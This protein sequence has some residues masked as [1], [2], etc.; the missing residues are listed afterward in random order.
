MPQKLDDWQDP[1][2]VHRNRQDGHTALGVFPDVA[3]ALAG[4]SPYSV[5]LDGTWKFALY[6]NPSAVPTAFSEPGY[7]DSAWA[8]ITVPGN[9]QLQGFDRPIYVNVQYPHPIDE[10]YGPMLRKMYENSDWNHILSIRIPEEALAIPLEPPAYN[11]TGLYRTRFTVPA[12]WDGR[13]VVLR[14]EGVDS[15]FHLWVNGKLVGFSTDSRLPAEFNLTPYLRPG[16]NVLAMAVY[17]WPVS[18]YLEDQDY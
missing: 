16:E 4:E 1:T 6:D 15:A 7:D 17:R 18:S 13:S 10:R 5:S 3:S 2:L 12:A 9:W 14:F 8:D 11:P